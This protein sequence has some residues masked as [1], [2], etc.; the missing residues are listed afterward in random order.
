MF[1]AAAI[2]V[3]VW[4]MPICISNWLCSLH[5]SSYRACL[6]ENYNIFFQILVLRI[7]NHIFTVTCSIFW[8]LKHYIFLS[9]RFQMFIESSRKHRSDKFLQTYFFCCYY[10]VLNGI[11]QDEN[12]TQIVT[13]L[14]KGKRQKTYR[15]KRLQSLSTVTV[16]V[17]FKDG[18]LFCNI[19]ARN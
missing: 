3:A 4:R 17:F 13:F 16:N 12:I 10:T 15:S 14:T 7:L 2:P 1:S 9:I 19:S 18:F 5:H 11:Y 6:P 8:S